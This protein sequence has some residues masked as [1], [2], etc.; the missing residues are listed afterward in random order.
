M[1]SGETVIRTGAVGATTTSSTTAGTGNAAATTASRTQAAAVA[2]TGATAARHHQL[3]ALIQDA[4][5]LP[6]DRR[7]H[8]H[9]S[10]KLC[11]RTPATA[12]ISFLCVE[13]AVQYS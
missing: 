11:L 7:K 10:G 1:W 9:T 2:T 3:S 4:A 6:R 13:A 5:A 12:L 8:R